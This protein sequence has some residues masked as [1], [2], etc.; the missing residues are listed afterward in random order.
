MFDEN[1]GRETVVFFRT[2]CGIP[3][4]MC[5]Y[6]KCGQSHANNFG[7]F[8][9]KPFYICFKLELLLKKKPILIVVYDDASATCRVEYLTV[10]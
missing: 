2:L 1:I 4:T 7:Q 6:C 8:I 10:S 9:N 3:G 5:N